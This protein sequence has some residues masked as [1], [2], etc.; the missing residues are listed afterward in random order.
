M[1]SPFAW[2]T[3]ATFHG[4]FG[5]LDQFVAILDLFSFRCVSGRASPIFLQKLLGA[6][7][8]L[9]LCFIAFQSSEGS[10][11]NG[12]FFTTREVTYPTIG[13]GKTSSKLLIEGLC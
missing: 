9:F 11:K 4:D 12:V 7:V 5:S 8:G 2:C 3:T 10:E 13:K 6:G 1:L